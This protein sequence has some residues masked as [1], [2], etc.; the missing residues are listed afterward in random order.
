MSARRTPRPTQTATVGRL[1]HGR[2]EPGNSHLP[3]ERSCHLPATHLPCLGPPDCCHCGTA[4]VDGRVTVRTRPRDCNRRGE[5]TVPG[6]DRGPGP[7]QRRRSPRQGGSRAATGG[8]PRRRCVG[9]SPRGRARSTRVTPGQPV[10]PTLPD[11]VRCGKSHP[12]LGPQRCGGQ[13]G[14]PGCQGRHSIAELDTGDSGKHP[15]TR[16]GVGR[17]QKTTLPPESGG[18]VV[19]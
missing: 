6:Q 10:V 18:R 5:G 2:P 15:L 17:K 1:R 12:G 9:D 7:N 16:A 8:S 13:F 3:R 11:R 4:T 14:W 19:E